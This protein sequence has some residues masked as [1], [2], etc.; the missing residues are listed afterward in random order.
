VAAAD[1][2]GAMQAHVVELGDG[3]AAVH[4]SASVAGEY[5]LA[6]KCAGSAGLVAGSAV[7]IRVLPAPAAVANCQVIHRR[8]ATSLRSG[9]TANARSKAVVPWRCRAAFPPMS[10]WLGMVDRTGECPAACGGEA[11][12]ACRLLRICRQC[13]RGRA[14]PGLGGAAQAVLGGAVADGGVEAGCEVA[15]ALE[16]RDRFGNAGAAAEHKPVVE[17][18]GPSAAV[19]ATGKD[20]VFRRAPVFR[21]LRRSW[22]LTGDRG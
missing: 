22:T 11:P 9:P 20:G 18:L 5:A 1:G 21:C 14:D 6:V 12:A 7:R 4:Y 10:A 16:L 17:A 15:V 2:P 13:V 8:A 3:S 19:F